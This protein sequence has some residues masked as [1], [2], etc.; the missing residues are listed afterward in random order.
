MQLKNFQNNAIGKLQQ[1]FYELWKAG[2]KNIPLVFKSPTGSGKTIMMAEFLHRVSGEAS[3][4]PDK[5]FVWISKGDLAQQSKKKLEN[6]YNIGLPWTKCLDENNLNETKLKKNEIFFVNWEKIISNSKQN[7]K[8]RITGESSISFDDFMENTH[9]DNR[10]LVLIVDESHLNLTTK[11]AKE[12]IDIIN[13]RISIY[14]SATPKD[15]PKISEVKHKK[16]GFVEVE[17]EEVIKEELIKESIKIMPKEEV[18]A[19]DTNQDLD[20]LLLDLAL[21]KQQSLKTQYKELGLKINPLILV[22]L[23]NDEK[24][25][26]AIEGQNKLEFCKDYLKNKIA[27]D[28]M[29]IWL[30][31]K[32]ENL[33]D[34]VQNNSVVKVLIFKQAIATGCDCPR[35]QILVSFREMKNPVF[36]TQVLGRIL[37]MPEAKHYQNYELNHSYCYTSYEKQ[38]VSDVINKDGDNSEKIY[39]AKIKS[40]INNIA[41]PSVFLSRTDYN[42]LSASFQ[43]TFIKVANEYF[44]IANDLTQTALSKLKNKGFDIEKTTITNQLIIDADI[45]VFDDFVNKLKNADEL[46]HQTSI[47]DIKKL[48][49]LLLQKEIVN[50]EDSSKFG[51]VA[52]SFGKLKSAINTW[53]RPFLQLDSPVYEVVCNDLLKG[54]SSVLKIVI[55]KALKEYKPIRDTEVS[56][57]NDKKRQDIMFSILPEYFYSSN[58]EME[59][60][61]RY[62]LDKSYIT[63]KSELE[64]KFIHFLEKQNNIDWWYKNAD[65]GREALGIEYKNKDKISSVFY[66]DFIIRQSDKIG[67]FDTKSGWTASDAK[68]KA[69]TLYSYCQNNKGV[70]ISG[71]L[72][73]EIKGIFKNGTLELFCGIV[74]LAQNGSWKIHTGNNY[75]A[76]IDN[77][78]NFEDYFLKA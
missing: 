61:K 40:G 25:T 49:D 58:N 50:Q 4:D 3:F 24:T 38:E 26:T 33:I 18:K 39:S 48:Y 2:N 22:Q 41:L 1:T 36:Q 5:C 15:E 57:K 56:Q 9:N 43:K 47:N 76:N 35:A 72:S 21:K 51:N 70:N 23:P 30:S 75:T 14:I 59:D 65:S 8:L 6:Y 13:P 55:E 10:E 7:R 53:L 68:E 45:E 66:P 54:D 67:I 52:R 37:R 20:S 74:Q 71:T 46:S 62:V 34:I 11:L 32:K 60:L 69:E 29:A 42:D 17:R 28:E 63:T 27:E 78:E 73:R 44:D 19:L 64:E 31:E 12:I 16:A 77:W